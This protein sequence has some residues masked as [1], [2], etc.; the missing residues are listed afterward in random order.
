MENRLVV[1]KGKQI[2]RTLL[3]DEWWFPVIDVCRAL[4][5]SQDAGLIGGN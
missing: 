3:N 1:F 5:D 2:R 4:T